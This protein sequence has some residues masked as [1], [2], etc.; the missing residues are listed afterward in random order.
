MCLEAGLTAEICGIIHNV[1]TLSLSTCWYNGEIQPQTTAHSYRWKVIPRDLVW[2]VQRC[3][4]PQ[5]EHE[6]GIFSA[7]H[8]QYGGEVDVRSAYNPASQFLFF[9]FFGVS[10][11]TPRLRS[12]VYVQVCLCFRLLVACIQISFKLAVASTSRWHTQK[13]KYIRTRRTIKYLLPL[14]CFQY[15]FTAAGS[16]WAGVTSQFCGTVLLQTFTS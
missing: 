11:S 1:S 2:K 6:W 9:F 12:Y 5:A 13:R 4:Q 16:S 15:I 7:C 3:V 10:E 14:Q 8:I